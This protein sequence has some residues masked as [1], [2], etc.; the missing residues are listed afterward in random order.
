M[1]VTP[2][3]L[4]GEVNIPDTGIFHVPTK[5]SYPASRWTLSSFGWLRAV[6]VLGSAVILTCPLIPPHG[7]FLAGDDRKRQNLTGEK[8][9]AANHGPHDPK[10]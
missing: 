2:K 1:A 3:G 10:S 5:Q 9:P 6:P 8:R 4:N 7:P